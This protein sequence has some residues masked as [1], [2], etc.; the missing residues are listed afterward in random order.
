LIDKG[1]LLHK[2]SG[3]L[4]WGTMGKRLIF[5]YSRSLWTM[6]ILQ[7]VLLILMIGVGALKQS[8]SFWIWLV[9]NYS[10]W[11][12]LIFGPWII[13]QILFW[14]VS[15]AYLYVDSSNKPNW[16]TKYRIQHGPPNRPSLKRTF[17]VLASNQLIFAPL[18]LFIMAFA[19]LYQGWT[20]NKTLPDVSV[21]LIEL[22][23]LGISS[24]I[25]FYTTHRFL[26]RPYWMKKVHCIHHEYR[27]TNA[28]AS[29][30][31][32]PIE[33]CLGNFGTLAGGVV[34]FSPSLTSIY[35]FT[36]LSNLTI[37]VHHGGYSLPW[38]PWAVP[39]DWHHF[40]YK[41]LF[42]TVGIMDRIFGT[43]KEFRTLK[44]GDTK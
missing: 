3:S 34:L 11:T 33:F 16:I 14:T 22:I 5:H 28:L 12:L 42:G 38:A 10:S 6:H 29:E 36:I 27:T 24:L 13:H 4:I 18:M 32:H 17:Q 41:E 35:I 21:V 2:Q 8:Q 20:P 40:R 30:Y 43:D 31:A 39:H 25:I 7:L 9:S 44:D 15:S 26:H 1:C 37:L 19:L 23:L